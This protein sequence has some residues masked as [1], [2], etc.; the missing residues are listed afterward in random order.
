[1]GLC[2]QCLLSKAG[3]RDS[4]TLSRSCPGEEALFFRFEVEIRAPAGQLKPLLRH[5]AEK[6]AHWRLFCVIRGALGVG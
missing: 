6:S 2:V 3:R 4:V 5:Q 1:M